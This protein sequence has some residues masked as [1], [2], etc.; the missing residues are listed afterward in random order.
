M[1]EAAYYPNNMS[2]VDKDT[3]VIIRI[4]RFPGFSSR[5]KRL[6]ILEPGWIAEAS[7]PRARERVHVSR[8]GVEFKTGENSYR[9]PLRE[10][11]VPIVV[12]PGTEVVIRAADGKEVGRLGPLRRFE[13]LEASRVPRREISKKKLR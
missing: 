7:S 1:N 3:V 5:R 6:V 12:R 2:R 8:E 4:K 10:G 9:H 11:P 13:T